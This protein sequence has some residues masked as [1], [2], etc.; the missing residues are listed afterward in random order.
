MC[1]AITVQLLRQK[2]F[3]GIEFQR[4]F[5]TFEWPAKDK[6]TAKIQPIYSISFE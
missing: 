2:L 4:G 6:V 1:S 5:E 3:I